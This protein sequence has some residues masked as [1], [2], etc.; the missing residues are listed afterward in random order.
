MPEEE[1]QS[2]GERIAFLREKAGL[3]VEEAAD[4]AGISVA[5]W[6]ACEE[7]TGT[8]SPR[9]KVLWGIAAALGVRPKKL[10]E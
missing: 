3:T 1:A 10:F 5:A 2:L 7:L 4:A 6:Q 9:L 8:R